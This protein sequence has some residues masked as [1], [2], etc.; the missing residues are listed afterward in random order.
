MGQVWQATD[1]TLNRQV[2]LKI[3]PDAFAEDPDRLAR[4]QREAQVLA[5]LNHPN[6]AAIYGIEQGADTRALVLELV[7]GPTLAD[8][9]KRGPIPVDEAL[10]IA[11]QIAEALE[12][13]HEAGVIH[14]DLKP[15][16]IKV[17]EDG[18]VKVLDFGLAKAFQPDATAD[19]NMSMSPTISLT[20][21]ATE[22]GMIIGTAAYM[23]PE[24]AKGK[25]VDKRADVWAF[26]AVLYE[27]LTGQKPFAGDDVSTTLAR[28]IEREPD[29]D[30]LPA[31]V[32]AR[33]RH[34]VRI[35]LDKNPRKR[36]GDI[37][38]IRLALDGAFETQA[39]RAAG[40][41][42]VRT[43]SRGWGLA[44]AVAL[45]S[46]GLVGLVGWSL[47]P[48][49]RGSETPTRFIIRSLGDMPL[50]V[51]T[52]LALSPDGRELVYA[53]GLGDES[54][55]IHHSLAD[56]EPHAIEGSRG[57]MTPF[58][59]PSGNAVGFYSPSAG[60]LQRLELTGGSP[61]P[62]I[63]TEGFLGA[64]WGEDGTLV[65]NASWA[66]PLNIVRPGE[67][68]A[69]GLT[70]LDAGTG[71]QGH[72][73]PQILPGD[74]GVL[75]TIW[76]GAPTWDESE[77]A[78]ADLKTGQHTTVLRGG[79]S[80]RY[81]ESGHLV[82]WRGNALMAVPFEV[83][84]LTAHGEPVRVVRDVRLEQGPGAAHFAISRGGTL[85]Y[86]GGGQDSFSE[87]FVVDRSGRRLSG[88]DETGAT[89][90]PV[91]SP[92]GTRVALTLYQ[93][94][95]YGI[96][97]FDIAS[98]RLTPVALD[99]DNVAPSWTSAGDRITFVSN[100]DGDY[101]WYAMRA[102]GSG[103]PEPL[104]AQS[105]GMS[106]TRSAWSP[107]GRYL[108]YG[109]GSLRGSDIWLHEPG[110]AAEP[111]PLIMTAA[112]ESAPAFSPDGRL[113]AYQSDESGA[114]EI[115]VRPFPETETRRDLISRS[116]GQRPVWS[117]DG[118]EVFYFAEDGVMRVPVTAGAD[119][120]P[121][122]GQPSLL[123]E[124]S[125]IRNFDGSPDGQSFAIERLPIETVAR[126][127][128]VVLNWFE[129]LKRLVPVN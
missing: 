42:A 29:W 33:I 104:F 7:E 52:P 24:Q 89:G 90:D 31:E 122:F 120:V 93:G 98:G 82:F 22:M 87:T 10:P 26:G 69:V 113:I 112:I 41:E 5:S 21:A 71:E 100:R 86:V 59:Y 84:T 34:V 61:T 110:G 57:A 128:H 121:R 16:N 108:A 20:A 94:G 56:F 1:T 101:N 62:L 46:A 64:S 51:D 105:Q 81:T 73:W 37:A 79:A 124:M 103:T 102:D 115:Y 55:L 75:F 19:P 68:E 88:L 117:T 43:P 109:R 76:S 127:I 114:V 45:L 111:H 118:S 116:G 39:D 58:F 107:D 74:R 14:R 48:R 125:G 95:A 67:T 47:T 28:V 129:E 97:V 65:F 13:A 99:R 53:V 123:F 44:A 30:A 11:R 4:F 3:L 32:H 36:G 54:Q 83:D 78:V 63:A 6:I 40:G 50:A 85:A 38:A 91:F 92:D 66:S 35:C 49:F 77:L 72:V 23:A 8:R 70:R 12:A 17:R 25:P 96:G 18:T 60:Q 15:A 2:A 80:G 119:G 106:L 9:I 126:E 27:M